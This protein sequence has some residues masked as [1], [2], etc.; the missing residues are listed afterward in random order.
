MGL[1]L[2][3]SRLVFFPLF[4][5]VFMLSGCGRVTGSC[6]RRATGSATCT[7]TKGSNLKDGERFDCQSSPDSTRRGTWND[8]KACDRTGAIGACD[9]NYNRIWYYP[10]A[11]YSKIEHIAT[12]CTIGGTVLGPD[13]KARKN[14]TPEPLPQVTN[15]S[16]PGLDALMAPVKAPLL[17]NVAA[18]EKLKATGAVPGT[19]RLTGGKHVLAGP[20]AAAVWDADIANFTD[21]KA[22]YIK[23]L[24]FNESD[25]I[26]ACGIG[27]RSHDRQGRSDEAMGKIFKWCAGLTTIIVV[28][29]NKLE[30][31]ER[32]GGLDEFYTGKADGTAY[33]Y[34]LPSGKLAGGFNFK[35]ENSDRVKANALESDFTA[36]TNKAMGAALAKADPGATYAFFVRISRN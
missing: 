22:E 12:T 26:H 2:S 20:T 3:G 33:V 24:P 18:I 1:Q 11:N 7:E 9:Y 30:L 8:G 34:E 19:V 15:L 21:R 5:V 28:H 35:A 32:K 13:G 25:D 6:D 27:V 31:P 14:L 17:A 16:D 10:G 23:K 4:A 36:N 29:A